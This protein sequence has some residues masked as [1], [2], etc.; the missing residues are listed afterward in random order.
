MGAICQYSSTKVKPPTPNPSPPRRCARGRGGEKRIPFSRRGCVRGV[1]T[2]A[3]RELPE[4]RIRKIDVAIRYSQSQCRSRISHGFINPG[5]DA[6][7]TKENVEAKRRQTQWSIVRTQAAY[8]RATERAACAH[9]LT[10]ALAYRRFSTALARRTLVP[11]AQL[12]AGF[13]GRGQSARPCRPPQPGRR[14]SAEAGVTPPLASHSPAIAPRATGRS[15]GQ[16]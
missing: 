13:L 8:G 16:A 9:P 6:E 11:K 2:V 12:Q 14:P 10:G 7:R 1:I 3:N 15:A 5:N 4:W